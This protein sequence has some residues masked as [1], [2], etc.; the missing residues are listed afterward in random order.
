MRPHVIIADASRSDRMDL[1]ASLSA[2]GFLV[3]ACDSAASTKKALST[4]T[5]D[6]AILDIDL[7]DDNGINLMRDIRSAG[8][9]NRLPVILMS[10]ESDVK[11]RIRGLAMGAN[12]CISKPYDSA[13]I[14]ACV[15]DLVH[16]AVHGAESGPP[17]SSTCA[18]GRK[19]LIV[20]DSH[21]YRLK[22]AEVLRQDRHNVIIAGSGEEALALLEAEPV[23][24]ILLDL[25]MPGTDGLD[26]CRRI[27]RSPSRRH[28]HILMMTSRDDVE[29]KR[30]SLAAGADDII[31]K[32]SELELLK[33]RLR[34]LL[35]TDRA[36]SAEAERPS[37]PPTPTSALWRKQDDVPRGSLLYRVVTRSG[38]SSM[39]GPSTIA[40]ACERVGVD[41]KKMTAADLMRALPAIRQTLSMFLSRAEADE[42]GD[43]IAV[44]AREAFMA[45]RPSWAAASQSAA[46]SR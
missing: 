24:A 38:L 30:A 31:V 1:R 26:V 16:G 8:H 33:V 21:T 45:M 12:A 7:P 4:R 28:M 32:S 46:P 18:M 2:A 15:Q 34:A 5:Y 11:L 27:R 23:D 14:V 10:N 41:A 20:D 17:P 35:K 19:I 37:A 22:L 25:M 40:R 43:A 42:R 44:L 13:Y 39:I 9:G 3:T 29:A 6:V 36:D